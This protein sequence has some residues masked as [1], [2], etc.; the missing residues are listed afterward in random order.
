MDPQQL[1]RRYRTLADR[2]Q[3]GNQKELGIEETTKLALA[4]HQVKFDAEDRWR[5]SLYNDSF[6]ELI[7]ANGQLTRPPIPMQDGWAIDRSMSL[8]YL[9][10]MLA[11]ADWIIA[12]RRSARTRKSS[13]YRSYFQNI[14]RDRDATRFPAFLN[15]ITSSDLLAVVCHYLQTIPALSTTLPPGIRLVESNAAFDDQPAINKDSQLFHTDYYSSPN[16]YVLVLLADTTFEHGPWTFLPRSTSD[17]VKHELGYW[18]RG[19]GYRLTDEEVESVADRTD[20]I[21][22]SAP[23]GPVL[24]IDSSACMHFGSRNSVKPR[25][26]LML[27]Y[28]GVCRTD[29]SELMI[30]PKRYPVRS[31]DALLR[32]LILDRYRRAPGQS[33]ELDPEKVRPL[34]QQ[35]DALAQPGEL[36]PATPPRWFQRL[37]GRR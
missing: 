18:K 10:E 36:R 19:K 34:M 26:Q 25:F 2:L 29:F 33:S 11:E 15:F 8:P 23:R 37:L 20:L 27:G 22:F 24:F 1:D 32:Q 28:S 21:E 3:A 17:R 5:R 35:L 9:H 31:S 13:R 14:W 12:E 6:V 30:K 7:E 16:V 4:Y